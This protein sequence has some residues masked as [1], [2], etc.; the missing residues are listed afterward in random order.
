MAFK[1]YIH[2]IRVCKHIVWHSTF[3][4]KAIILNHEPVAVMVRT[5]CERVRN[6]KDVAKTQC[7]LLERAINVLKAWYGQVQCQSHCLYKVGD[8]MIIVR[9]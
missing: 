6:R 2:E 7:S 9:T 3:Y 4:I 8:S 5:Y 1:Y